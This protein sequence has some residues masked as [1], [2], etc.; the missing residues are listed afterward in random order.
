LTKEI[1]LTRGLKAL[2]DDEDYALLNQWKW[3]ANYAHNKV[4]ASR[5][6]GKKSIYMHKSI[7]NTPAGME[8]DHKDGNGINN[9]KYNLRNCTHAQNLSNLGMRKNNTSG[10]KGVTWVARRKR[11][12]AQIAV[13]GKH[14]GLGYYKN[15]IDAAKAYD[16]AA[17]ENF[18]EYANINIK[19]K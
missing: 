19:E 16:E 7:M 6:E 8:V 14:I 15:P 9:Q 1:E 10:Y 17:I 13:R 3:C 18:G 2:V 12:M 11:F 4:Y 5:K